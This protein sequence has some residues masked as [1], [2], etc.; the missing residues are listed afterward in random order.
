MKTDLVILGGGPAG[1]TA[2]IRAAKCGMSVVL[3]EK[4][5]VGGTCLNRGCIPTK[6]L[7]HSSELYFSRDEWESL[8]VVA[9][10]VKFDEQ[11]VYARKEKTVATLRD[12]I[13]SL[14]KAGK[15]TLVK[16][17][18]KII[19]AHSVEADEEVFECDKML[20]ATGSRPAVLNVKG[21]EKALTSDEVLAR[22]VDGKEIVI[23]GGGVIGTEFA[24]YFTDLGKTVTVI[25]YAD[26]ILPMM[27][28]EISVQLS[29]VLKRKNATIR[30]SARVTEIGDGFVRFEDKNGEN[31]VCCDAVICAAGRRPNVENIGLEN[32]GLQTDRAIAVDENMRTEVPD[33]YAAGDVAQG[34]QLAHYAAAGALKAVCAMTGKGTAPDL[35]VVPSLVYTQP[36]IAVVG[37]LE[38]AAKSGKFLLGANGKSLINGSNRGF[39]KVYCD[40]KDRVLGA[41]LFGTGV[42]EIVG[43]LALAI[44]NGLTAEQVAATIHAHPTVY[45]SVAE[46]CEDVFGLA[47]HKR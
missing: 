28:K 4:D 40:D 22:P 45:E 26:R 14:L 19:S 6:C 21:A 7:L 2:A 10:D 5:N 38:G 31:T 9:S 32:I 47:T 41:E 23:V 13:E 36:E 27:S 44:K 37:Q 20:I 3:V 24:S 25:E 33:V 12:G 1:Y 11:A 46:A 17:E 15:V 34:I 16:G 30:T 39:I 29:S 42:T 18:G 43:E 8:G 35:S